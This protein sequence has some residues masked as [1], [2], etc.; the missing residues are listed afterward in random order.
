[1]EAVQHNW[2]LYLSVFACAFGVAI[3]A[4]PFAKKLSVK[5]GA[6]DYPRLRSMHAEPMPR[7]GGV[8]IVLGFLAA[9]IISLFF[10]PEL[11][12]TQ[13][14]GVLGG[15]FIIVAEGMLDDMYD[16][17]PR[18]KAAVQIAAALLVIFSGTRI[19][20][21]VYPFETVF[22]SLSIPFTL[23][24]IVG[25]V[26][27]VNLIDGLD[28]L[29]AGVSTIAAVCLLVLCV[30]SGNAVAVVLAA[31][32]A[33]SCLGFL[34]RNFNPA[35]VIMGDTGAQFLGYVLAV[36]SIM[37][38]FKGYALLAVVITFFALA[39][40]IFDTLFAMIRRVLTHKPIMSA[41]RGHLHHRLI[42]LGYTH[43]QTVIILYCLS[44]ITGVIAIVIAM[45]DL[46]AILVTVICLL[47]MLLMMFVYRKRTQ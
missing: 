26:N 10:L 5:L 8:A 11:A 25:V 13:F 2:L 47:V 1:V 28:G 15:A 20:F 37:G 44:I 22:H 39:L 31:A 30:L 45:K 41:D 23:I 43:K 40:P 34:P 18:T 35:E 38:V 6:V 46:R 29:A 4:T 24:W 3:V 42:D 27:A 21:V 9:M 16:L 36:S 14:L 7:M 33:G 32:L 12:K 17:R 19:E